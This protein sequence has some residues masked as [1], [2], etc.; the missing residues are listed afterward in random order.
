MSAPR[1]LGLRTPPLWSGRVRTTLVLA[2]LAVLLLAGCSGSDDPVQPPENLTPEQE[3]TRFIRANYPLETTPKNIPY[4]PNNP[5]DDE[6][7]ALGRLVFFDPVLSGDGDVACA[8]CHHPAF[9]WGDGLPVSIGVGGEGIGPDRVATLPGQPTE[10]TT[11]RNSP[12]VLDVAFNRP[13]AGEG[14]H[15]G[16]MFWDGRANG[17]EEQARLPVRS[18][19]EMRHDAYTAPEALTRVLENLQ[20]IDEYVALFAAAFPAV[21]DQIENAFGPGYEHLVINGDTYS[22]A[23][24][25]Y[26]RELVTADSPYD[27][28]VRGADDALTY[29]QKRGLDIFHRVG[30]FECHSGPM[31]SDYEFHALGVKQGGS[32]KPPIHETGDG[33]DLGRYLESG[34]AEDRNAFRTPT[35]RNIALT[36]PYF[37]TGGVETGGDYQTL[38]SVIEFHRRGGNDEG[39]PVEALSPDLKAIELLEPEVEDLIAFLE[40]LT[41]ARLASDRVDPTVPAEVPSGLAPPP[42]LPPV[43]TNDFGR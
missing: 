1:P 33:S 24:A 14:E 25:A 36:A 5:P 19:D 31:F 34:R 23:L 27:R 41:A 22:R 12:T 21:A 13:F 4:P 6:V 40:S 11:P 2:V 39:L 15:R 8:T 32:G 20:A 29:S 18:R 38:R 37:H 42:I 28:F 17:L 35:L 16:R 26:Q 7:I 9:A 30:C 10:F 43:L 3:L